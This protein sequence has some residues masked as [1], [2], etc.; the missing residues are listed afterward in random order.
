[1]L[2]SFLDLSHCR[3]QRLLER[4][5][6]RVIMCLGHIPDMSPANDAV[7]TA[8]IEAYALNAVSPLLSSHDNDTIG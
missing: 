3:G 6:F 5:E 4:P 2:R 8:S 7:D 1:V